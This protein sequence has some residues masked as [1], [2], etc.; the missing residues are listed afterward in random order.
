[1]P[2]QPKALAKRLP[3]GDMMDAVVVKAEE[4]KFHDVYSGEV[5]M[6][7]AAPPE[8]I[9]EILADLRT[10]VV[11]GGQTNRMHQRL[12]TIEAPDEPAT[13]GTTFQSVG[14]TSHGLWHDRSEVTQA[15]PSS[16]FEFT[17]N[18]TMQSRPP[19]HGEWI[20]RYE[21]EPDGAGSTINYRCRWQLTKSVGDRPRL[22]R[23]V[24]CQLVLPTI[25]ETGLRGLA[26]MAAA[27][28]NGSGSEG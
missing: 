20:H 23:S 13:V 22:R 18:G 5:S 3:A 11:W 6:S 14:Y 9:Y 1:M 25:W 24:F 16:V 15:T 7:C 19:F 21:I 10:H 27:R 4:R 26:D 8:V 28:W 17:T 12:L 2:A